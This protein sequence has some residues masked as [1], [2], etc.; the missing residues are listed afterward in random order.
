MRLM[1]HH[2][3]NILEVH[4]STCGKLGRQS[5]PC[6]FQVTL[7]RAHQYCSIPRELYKHYTLQI[8]QF[9]AKIFNRTTITLKKYSLLCSYSVCVWYACTDKAL[10]LVCSSTCCRVLDN[11]LF[12][13]KT[14]WLSLHF[15]R[16][17]K[18]H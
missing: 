13:T 1:N 14:P 16:S 9:D 3:H 2:H 8:E 5:K 4:E 10:K 6:T 18:Q 17:L 11:S 15:A 12:K 7:L